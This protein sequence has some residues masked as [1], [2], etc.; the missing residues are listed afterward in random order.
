M[1]S[2]LISASALVDFPEKR[3]RRV[4]SRLRC[5]Y[6]MHRNTFS[7]QVDVTLGCG[8]DL[9]CKPQSVN[10]RSLMASL[11]TGPVSAPAGVSPRFFSLIP[12]CK[13]VPHQFEVKF[14]SEEIYLDVSDRCITL[15]G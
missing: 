10:I 13:I 2:W 12:P 6:H 1:L 9:S 15:S 3:P 14:D 4:D 7:G 11:H 8:N 5:G